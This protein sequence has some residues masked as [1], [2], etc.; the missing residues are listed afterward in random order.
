[1][2][3]DL[4][5]IPVSRWISALMAIFLIACGGGGYGGGGGG[6]GS[7]GTVTAYTAT[8]T[9]TAEVPPNN[10]TAT[11]SGTFSF[12]SSTMSLTATVTTS[13]IV[14]TA[15]HIHEGA[16][17]MAGSIIFPLAPAGSGKWSTT[18]TLTNAQLTE[19]NAGRYYVNVHS[20]LYPAGEI[21]GQIL[22]QAKTY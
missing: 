10:S 11:G 15:A 3:I 19:L 12:D 16:V 20:T 21:R 14:G 13:N 5:K 2:E 22:S 9:G 1:M 7:S 6:G 17:G 8:L 18:V 4:L